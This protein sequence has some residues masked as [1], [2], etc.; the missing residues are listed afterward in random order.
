MKKTLLLAFAA[1]CFVQSALAWGKS[2]HDAVAYIAETHLTK[3]A[4]AVI[5]RYLGHSIVYDASWMDDYRAEPGYEMT[6][7]WHVDYGKGEP[8]KDAAGN[9]LEPN[10]LRELNRAIERLRDYRNLDDSTVVVNLRYVIHLVGDMH[11]PAHIRYPGNTTIGYYKVDYFGRE[12]RYHT[13]WDSEI[14]QR[15]HPWSFTDLAWLL[16]RYTEAEQAEITS[17]T[18]YDW[19]R[20]SAAASKCI[21][22]VQ[23][24]ESIA[25]D[26]IKKYKP[27][28]E[29]QIAKAGY[30]LA[31][32]LNDVFGK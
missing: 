4:K 21:Y 7:W 12:M 30:R 5:E 6:N 26:F 25:N 31:A 27:L 13:I 11:C 24:G 1:L 20:E 17:G 29:S 22:D 28:A 8:T 10:V 18:V 16:D 19:G 23:P 3:R 32:V 9:P 15:P 14:V 2:G